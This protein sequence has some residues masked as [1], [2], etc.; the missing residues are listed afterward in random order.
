MS[1]LTGERNSVDD[2]VAPLPLYPPR[3]G[4]VDV[5]REAE[6]STQAPGSWL[7]GAHPHPAPSSSPTDTP[8]PWGGPAWPN[9]ADCICRTSS[10]PSQLSSVKSGG[11]PLQEELQSLEARAALTGQAASQRRLPSAKPSHLPFATD[12]LMTLLTACPQAGPHISQEDVGT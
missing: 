10:P 7:Q 2:A 1:F 3:S 11:S 5:A 6:F 9:C 4:E 12:H 8:A